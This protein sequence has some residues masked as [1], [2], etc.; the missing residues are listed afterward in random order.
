MKKFNLYIF[1]LIFFFL[2]INKNLFGLD[3]KH[4]LE[5]ENYLNK[6]KYIS[7]EFIQSSSDGYQAEGKLFLSKPGKLRIEYKKK[8][9]LLIIADGKWLHY[10][11]IELNEIQ[12]IVIERSPAWFLLKKKINFKKDFNIK[13]LIKASGKTTLSLTKDN[14]ENVKKIT[15]IFS[16]KPI[17]LKKWIIID[18]QD[19]ETTVSLL[20]IKKEKS[21][22]KNIFLL[23]K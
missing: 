23:I 10:F 11:D 6:L 8:E 15:L 19:I 16:T 2:L 21:F 1:F 9:N 20:N 5:I 18:F 13:K 7:S 4:L 3:E 14:L 22:N 12:S 17:E